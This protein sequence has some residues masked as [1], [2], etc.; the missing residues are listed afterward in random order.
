MKYILLLLLMPVYQAF[1]QQIITIDNCYMW[2]RENYPNLKHAQIRKEISDLQKENSHTG[3]LPRVLL[4][5]QATYQSDVTGIGLAL[6][7]ISIP[8]VSKDQYK[9]YA[10]IRQ[11]IW[12]GGL[13]YAGTQLEEAVLQ[14]D[15]NRLE[16]EIYKLNEQVSQAFFTILAVDKQKEVLAAQKIVLSE[17]L[18]SIQSGVKNQVVEKSAALLV[19]AE[20][21]NIEQNEIELAAAK[22]TA[23][24]I[25]VILTG[26][27]FEE[28]SIFHYGKEDIK[29]TYLYARPEYALF[30]AQ[31][32]QLE[33]ESELIQKSRNPILFGFGQAGYG[34]PALNMLSDKFDTYCLVGAGISWNAFD[35]KKTA[36][37]KQV[38]SLQQQIID[39]QEK[40]FNQN[41]QILLA[42]QN[43]Q[44]K[45]FEKLLETDIEMVS[46]QSEIAQIS[47]SKLENETITMADYIQD[48][49]S[50][51]IA[52]LNYEL[53]KIGLNEAME[54]YSLIKGKR[55]Q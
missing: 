50:E 4:N 53:H 30:S 46:L 39:H 20:I 12:D 40:T 2:A 24:R 51:T 41:L 18:K 26:K 48:L 36:R 17:K 43:E 35:W 55:V 5:G 54:K 31:K 27:S 23:L 6:P 38:I 45:K 3:Y 52:K 13:T 33:K 37:Q 42:Q 22:K 16:V 19:K 8:A 9:A 1:G 49:Q 28:N 25:L 29:N 7:N 15:L 10:E 47:A 14:N 32:T 21:F 34:R 44:I 11:T